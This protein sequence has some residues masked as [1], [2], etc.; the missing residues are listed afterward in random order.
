MTIDEL[1]RRFGIEGRV[2]F[3]EG[4]GGLA[5]ALLTSEHGAGSVFLHGAHV[6]SFQPVGEDPVLW[7][8]PASKFTGGKAIRGGI[9][10]CWPWFG[11]HPSDG[12]KP[13][14]GFA[15]TSAFKVDESRLGDDGRVRLGLLLVDDEKSRSLWPHPFELRIIV[16]VGRDLVVTASVRNTGSIPFTYTCALHTYLD[17]ADVSKVSVLGLEGTSYLDKFDGG[18]EKSN[19]GSLRIAGPTDAV[20]LDTDKKCVVVDPG[21]AR[22]L[23]V[24]KRG[25]RTTVVWNPWEDK[26]A[27]MADMGPGTHKGM[28]CVEAANA[29]DDVVEVAPGATHLLETRIGSERE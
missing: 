23:T 26:A 24:G 2:R 21:R 15:R 20:F 7:M 22:R 6:A 19:E 17:V 29:G 28:I 1:N 4:E 9:P 5:K 14:H 10:V 18:K 13:A 3:V 8:S 11:D 16:G 27:S 25:S 12:S